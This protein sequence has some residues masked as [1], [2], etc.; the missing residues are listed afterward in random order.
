MFH[1]YLRIDYMD[2]QMVREMK[3]EKNDTIAIS[4][5]NN[6]DETG[7]GIEHCNIV[8]DSN[9]MNQDNHDGTYGLTINKLLE[10]TKHGMGKK[11]FTYDGLGGNNCQ[12][13]VMAILQYNGLMEANPQAKPFVFQD[14]SAME[15]TFAR[16]F[17]NK[18]TGLSAR[19]NVA[20]LG[21]G[22]YK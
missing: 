19:L 6:S 8:L 18:V 11:Y 10:N 20:L 22:L 1:L 21:K 16:Q 2:G 13:F 15:N 17:S 3:L 7:A 12:N 14:L 9:I 5:F 4:G